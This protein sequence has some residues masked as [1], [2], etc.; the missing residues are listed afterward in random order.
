MERLVNRR[1]WNLIFLWIGQF[2]SAT[3]DAVLFPALLFLVL[4]L[5]KTGGGTKSGIVSLASTLPF[6]IFGLIAGAI[7][8]RSRR[9]RL[10]IVSDLARAALLVFVPV[11]Y[12]LGWLNWIVVGVVAFGVGT[13]TAL[14]NPARDALI[15]DVDEGANLVRINSV[16]QT[17]IQSAIVVGTGL[18]ALV[19]GFA[20]SGQE[21]P[22]LVALFGAD[23]VSFLVSACALGV[24]RLPRQVR[25][26]QASG[27]GSMAAEIRQAL[28]LVRG[29]SA[30]SG[31]LFI[32]AVDNLFIMGPA[33]V[34]ANLFIRDT[35][36]QGPQAMALFEGVLA[37]GWL[38]A[39]LLLLRFAHAIRKGPAV[40]V[41]IV[42]DGLT[43]IP[44]FWIRTLEWLL[45]A[46]FVHALAIPLIVVC[47]TSIVQEAVPKHALGKVFGLLNLT[48]FGF[49]ALS[50]LLTGIAADALAIRFGATAPPLVFLIS[51]I[52]GALCGVAA[53]FFSG[54]R[55]W[56]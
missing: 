3:G 9:V 54:L 4:A 12:A 35:L 50:S 31:L 43:Y 24:M 49:W 13:F 16:F 36:Q 25:R 47:R 29:S 39:T 51:G 37:V 42:L 6:L 46:I 55:Q 5:E 18:A 22:M 1:R 34:G 21:V 20:G 38:L 15:P 41:G 27:T 8:D 53:L 48:I 26:P 2:I 7:V 32:T 44:F 17:S 14:F 19:L 33:T 23:G 28:G 56:R 40:I 30:L 45:V 11:A 52:G 10:M